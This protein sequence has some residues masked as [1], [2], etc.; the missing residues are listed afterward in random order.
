M[1]RGAGVTGQVWAGRVGLGWSA[2]EVEAPLRKL[3]D[4]GP[5]GRELGLSP[6]RFWGAPEALW[7]PGMGPRPKS[8][9]LQP[10]PSLGKGGGRRDG[11]G[12][13]LAACPLA[14]WER[15]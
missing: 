10:C 11:G 4:V 3:P 12:R 13:T 2:G 1:G 7:A 5:K 9:D 6:K 15:R 14:W 8:P